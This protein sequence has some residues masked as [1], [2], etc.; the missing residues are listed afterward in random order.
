M[1]SQ[2]KL[3]LAAAFAGLSACAPSAGLRGEILSVD[4]G[5]CQTHEIVLFVDRTTPL[6]EEAR[7]LLLDGVARIGGAENIAGHLRVIEIGDAAFH[8]RQVFEACLPA[9]ARTQADLTPERLKS[10]ILNQ[11]ERNLAIEQA[12][13]NN[14]ATNAAI[15][16]RWRRT[17]QSFEAFV[18]TWSQQSNTTQRS[19]IASA[20]FDRTV[21]NCAGRTCDVFAFSDL[22]DSA[23]RDLLSRNPELSGR[24]YVS[25]LASSSTVASAEPPQHLSVHVWGF[26]RAEETANS[27]LD[28][29]QA[30]AWNRFWV[31][32]F[33]ALPARARSAPVLSR[34][35]E[36]IETS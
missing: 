34:Q 14:E 7:T 2:L 21:R 22:I 31:A 15:R 29:T 25:T 19:E 33:E 35:L 30:F 8:D 5:I 17:R 12:R 10:G 13:L 26:T 32:F 20:I 11:T 1:R 27:D 36:E 3:A 23:V 28:R 16:Q 6:S 18:Q 4:D 24:D 9:L